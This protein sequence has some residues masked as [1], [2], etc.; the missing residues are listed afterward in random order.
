MTARAVALALALGVMLASAP[1]RATE[2]YA[3]EV[4]QPIWT[5]NDIS[6]S[7]VTYL[8]MV[9]SWS[10]GLAVSMIT[11]RNAI[12]RD[13][14]PEPLQRNAAVMY[15]IRVTVLRDSAFSR[16]S[17]MGRDTVDTLVVALDLR[18]LNAHATYLDASS[19]VHATLECILANA[20]HDPPVARN[21]RIVVRGSRD[22]AAL[23]QV[24]RL[25]DYPRLPRTRSF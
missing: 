19:V 13:N 24:Y 2:E 15:G 5:P 9:G 1:A 4:L 20:A 8:T 23:G 22:Y 17:F 21:V 18:R 10:P 6:L 7:S 3:L 25:A 16:H 12:P 11:R 14:F